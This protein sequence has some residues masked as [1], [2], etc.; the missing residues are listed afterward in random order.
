MLETPTPFGYNE[1]TFEIVD[2]HLEELNVP[3]GLVRCG[4]QETLSITS[5]DTGMVLDLTE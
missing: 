5:L 3:T 2:R 4:L 1:D